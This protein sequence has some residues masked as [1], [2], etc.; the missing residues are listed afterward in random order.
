MPQATKPEPTCQVAR[1]LDIVGEKWSWLIVRNA[2]RGQTR[3]SQ[4]RE[5]LGIPTDILT[6]RLAKLVDAGV[7]E[8][9]TYREEGS[10]ERT[11]YHLT[12]KGEALRV[13]L[14][15]M[16]QWGDEFNPSPKGR[17]SLVL[18]DA[19]DELQ[20]AYVDAAGIQHTDV[21]IAPGPAATTRW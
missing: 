21:R 15:A 9:R 1:T 10:R 16:L 2:L 7:L 18:D 14:A 3:F 11:S 8:K 17:S 5:Q 19:G 20:L 12:P 4:F 6:A 13:V